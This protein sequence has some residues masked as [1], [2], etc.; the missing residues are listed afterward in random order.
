MAAVFDALVSLEGLAVVLALAYLLLAARENM[1]CWLCALVS[2]GLYV[3][4]FFDAGLYME[5]GLNIFYVLMALVGW[6]EWKLGGAAH[7]G[8]RIVRMQRWQHA[9]M[10]LAMLLLYLLGAW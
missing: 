10:L 1:L 5:T 4:I 3:G 2:S 8:V 9:V 6:Y 7:K